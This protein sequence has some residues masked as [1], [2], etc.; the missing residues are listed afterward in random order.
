[1]KK[2]PYC[3]AQYPDS[4]ENCPVDHNQLVV[5]PGGAGVAS[6][7]Q[8]AHAQLRIGAAGRWL[9]FAGVPC[10]VVALL[11]VCLEPG[12]LIE[13][14]VGEKALPYVLYFTPAV[15]VILGKVLYERVPKAAVIPYGVVGWVATA[16]LLCW[17]FWFGPG[18]L[19][20]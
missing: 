5:A 19:K 12:H 18:A 3:G 15:V 1:M 2:C 10:A 17:F 7:K 9:I 4:S 11:F 13:R 6:R 20:L 14:V 16:S 8:P